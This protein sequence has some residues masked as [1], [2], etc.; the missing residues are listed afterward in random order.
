M[1]TEARKGAGMVLQFGAGGVP[2]V[3]GSGTAKVIID[4]DILDQSGNKIG[5]FYDVAMD[6]V[7]AWEELAEELG[8]VP[9]RDDPE[10][11]AQ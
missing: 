5:N 7:K 10:V 3:T 4:G 11:S 8:I 9:H 2:V 1:T 6:A